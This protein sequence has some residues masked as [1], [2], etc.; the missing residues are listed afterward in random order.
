[1]TFNSFLVLLKSMSSLKTSVNDTFQFFSSFT[2]VM[3]V[4]DPMA[5]VSQPLSILF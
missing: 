4:P 2:E 1:M 3:G 5:M